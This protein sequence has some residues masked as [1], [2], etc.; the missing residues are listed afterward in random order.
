[1]N[2]LTYNAALAHLV[3]HSNCLVDVASEVQNLGNYYCNQIEIVAVGSE[4]LVIAVEDPVDLVW[5]TFVN[6]E[7]ALAHSDLKIFN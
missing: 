6:D 5:D 4:D 2:T 3:V 7:M 1:M